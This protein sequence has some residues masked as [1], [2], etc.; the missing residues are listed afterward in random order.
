MF[1]SVSIREEVALSSD[2]VDRRMSS[3][4]APYPNDAANPERLH[5]VYRN[6]QRMGTHLRSERV[7]Q[8][9]MRELLRI[10]GYVSVE[11]QALPPT[12]TAFTREDIGKVN[13]RKRIACICAK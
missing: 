8:V 5:E 10:E 6:R 7:D 13:T 3:D 1:P 4:A 2:E 9:E 11:I 12:R